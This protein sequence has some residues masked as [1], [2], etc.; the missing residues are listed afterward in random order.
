MSATPPAEKLAVIAS[1]CR[2]KL[3]L[4][5]APSRYDIALD[6]SGLR[7]IAHYDPADLTIS[8]GAG[9]PIAA[10]NAT[11]FQHNQFLPLLVPYYS[12]ATIGGTIASGLDSPLRQLYGTARDFLLGAEFIDGTGSQVKSGGR[13]VKNVTGYDLHK[14]L[15][16]SLGSLAVITRLNF[17]TF[18]A[19]AAGSRGFVASFSTHEAALALRDKIVASPLAPLTL[20]LLNPAAA[21]IFATRTPSAPEVPVFAGENHAA[22]QLPLPLPG[23]WFSRDTWQVCAAFAGVPEVL[24][25]CSRDLTRLAEETSA[26]SATFLDDS[27][28][29]SVWGRLREASAVVSGVSATSNDLP[30]QRSARISR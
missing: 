9:M 28:R 22:P 23:N 29:P 19:P 2:T 21:R 11:L 13:V 3:H 12:S 6:M 14:M 10:L 1:G 7:E 24:N 20:D 15:V 16:G 8:V 25:R 26:A 27:T 17:R 30:A 4:G 5:A 18:P